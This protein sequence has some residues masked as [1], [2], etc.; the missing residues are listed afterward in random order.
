MSDDDST[1]LSRR[2]LFSIAATSGLV[3]T[4]I[5]GAGGPRPDQV[6]AQPQDVA[7]IDGILAALYEVIS[8]PKGRPRD[9]DR[10]RSLF[11]PNARLIPF[12]PNGT[13][14]KAAIRMLTVD[15]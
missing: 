10:M 14:G 11:V 1:P 7:D 5:S 12:L 2:H 13:D 6:A 4:L 3:A 15:E 8:G 9:W